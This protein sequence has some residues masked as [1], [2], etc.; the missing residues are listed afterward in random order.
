[1]PRIRSIEYLIGNLDDQLTD[2]GFTVYEGRGSRAVDWWECN[3]CNQQSEDPNELEHEGECF[4][5]KVADVLHEA[6][7]ERARI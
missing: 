6:W 2:L 1:M 4:V 3:V 5:G 7:I